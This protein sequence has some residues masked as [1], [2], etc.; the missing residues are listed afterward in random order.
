VAVAAADEAE[1][2]VQ[3]PS[4][5]MRALP[6]P[7]SSSGR[8]PSDGEGGGG[9]WRQRAFNA[10]KLLWTG[11][12][13]AVAV[14]YLQ[15]N[16][17]EIRGYAVALGWMPVLVALAMVTIG[18][19]QL[20]AISVS[21]LHLVGSGIRL[22][23]SFWINA[24]SQ[25]GKY[26]PGSVWHLVGRVAIY[27]Q[28]GVPTPRGSAVLVVENL[29]LLGSALCVGVGLAFDAVVSAVFG[30]SL[31]V[32]TPAVRNLAGV[33][34]GLGAWWLVVW[35]LAPSLL[36]KLSLEGEFDRGRI[37]VLGATI[38]L[39][40]GIAFWMLLPAEQ[41]ALDLLPVAAGAFALAWTVGNLA[42]FA[43]AG[44]GVREAVLVALL[45][46]AVGVPVAIGAAASSRIVWTIGEFATA[47]VA[48][49]Q[50][51][52]HEDVPAL[53]EEERS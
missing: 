20:A 3:V 19:L 43:P 53:R 39:S 29:V 24:M 38:W 2:A 13:L 46:P 11:L 5:A 7:A 30:E 33:L 9:T 50:L 6:S 28:H 48:A 18:R 49:Y 26:L 25:L 14:W 15:A 1:W 4:A 27:R 45:G 12:I 32:G 52:R 41:R 51:G 35:G 34:L 40:F 16:W 42:P 21:A 23:L 17:D 37:F 31:R 10:V 8:G 44:I 36:R 22:G 47:P